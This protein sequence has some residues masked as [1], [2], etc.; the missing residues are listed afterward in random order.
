MQKKKITIHQLKARK[1]D[2]EKICAV[3]AYDYTSARLVD[4]AGVD[5]ILVGDSVANTMMGLDS[6]VPVT[7]S[8]MIYHG[9][10]VMRAE[11]RALVAIDMPFGS[12]N[13]GAER[14]INRA[15]K[16]FKRTGADAVKIEGGKSTAPVVRA[17]VD[18]GIPV[19]GHVGLMP[20]YRS[21]LGGLKVQGKELDAARQIIEDAQE[22]AAAGVF[23]IVLEAVPMRLAELIT[24]RI[25]VP[26]IGIGAG[27]GCDGQI[28]VLHDILGLSNRTPKFA[29]RWADLGQ[30]TVRA[31][32]AYRE[33]VRSGSF[34]TE[35]HSFKMDKTILEKL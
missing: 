13:D 27:A 12:V 3:T 23:S 16:V 2:G 22:I 20:Q 5:L 24:S 11:P 30:E 8:Q 21:M 9:K 33:A 14:A 15:V 25:D 4:Q 26:T 35:E 32:S 28:L 34:P 7:L 10:I 29:G 19:V 17:V 6:T 31:V 18:A 1:P